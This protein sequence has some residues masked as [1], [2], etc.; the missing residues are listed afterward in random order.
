MSK[1]SALDEALICVI[2]K[3]TAVTG[4]AIDGVKSVTGKTI[5]F[6]TAQAP[7]LIH[8]LLVWKLTEAILYFVLSIISIILCVHSTKKLY[9]SSDGAVLLVTEFLGLFSIIIS[10]VSFSDIL[11]ITFAPKIYL[12]EYAAH[13][14]RN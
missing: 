1:N 12:I 5:D 4:E 3:T 13:L 11:Q 2:N 8:Q 14:L 6:V 7:E 10:A 9:K